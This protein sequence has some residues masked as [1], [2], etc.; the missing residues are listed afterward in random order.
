M[1]EGLS[2][3]DIDALLK[4]LPFFRDK[5]NIFY[6]I[7][8]TDLLYPH[9]YAANVHKFFEV[10]YK[11]KIIYNFDW[12][13]WQ[14]EAINYYNNPELLKKADITTLRKLLTLHVRKDRFCDGHFGQI[15]KSGH[16]P[17]I[18]ER[19]EDIRKTMAEKR[20]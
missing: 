11:N 10:L 19:L 4:F 16:L 8:K 12:G 9:R 1:K 20:S 6:T 7:D 14:E 3:K 2:L 15:I 5:G 13:S 18:L 17:K